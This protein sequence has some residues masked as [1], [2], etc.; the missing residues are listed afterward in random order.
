MENLKGR[1]C[2]GHPGT[3]CEVRMKLTLQNMMW[4][5]RLKSI[6]Y[7]QLLVK[8]SHAHD[9]KSSCFVKDQNIIAQPNDWK[10]PVKEI[11]IFHTLSSTDDL[12]D[13]CEQKCFLFYRSVYK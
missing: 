9:N 1:S 6:F 10:F 7:G 4:S 3:D 5:G 11:F 2:F 13:T 8:S 12:T